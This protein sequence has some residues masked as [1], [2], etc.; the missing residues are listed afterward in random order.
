[1]RDRAVSF[2]EVIENSQEMSEEEKRELSR[3]SRELDEILEAQEEK[4]EQKEAER[5]RRMEARN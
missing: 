1:M 2:D 4:W 5:R 3:K